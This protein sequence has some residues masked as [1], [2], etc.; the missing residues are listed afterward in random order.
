[1]DF[2]LTRHAQDVMAERKIPLE[3]VAHVIRKPVRAEPDKTVSG[4]EH[5]LAVI[6]ENDGSC[7]LF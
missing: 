3:W 1:M 7:G 2:E 4:F 6:H 5:R